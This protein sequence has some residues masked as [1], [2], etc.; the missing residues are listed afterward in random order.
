MSD[1]STSQPNRPVATVVDDK[2]R[3]SFLSSLFGRETFLV[4]ENAVFTFMGWLSPEDYGGGFWEFYELDGQALYMVPP[5][6]DRYRMRCI[7]NGF[8]GEVSSDAAG[9]IVT[10]FTLSHLSF[11][12]E[13]YSLGTAYQRLYEY[14]ASHP[15]ASAIFRAID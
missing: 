3:E 4:A 12:F 15:E 11:Q 7:T 5:D 1:H 2:G 9:I 10:L 14:A 6:K 13:S 8:S